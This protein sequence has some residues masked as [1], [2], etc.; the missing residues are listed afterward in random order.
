MLVV[1]VVQ[2]SGNERIKGNT[3]VLGPG[4]YQMD[5]DHIRRDQALAKR[6]I[7]AMRG[8]LGR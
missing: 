4:E 1:E 2:G 6:E 7:A 3:R 5:P 8:F